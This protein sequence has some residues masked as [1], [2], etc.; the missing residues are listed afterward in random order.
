MI[1]SIQGKVIQKGNDFLIIS[2]AG[3]G[4]QVFATHEVVDQAQVGD[5]ISLFSQLIVREDSLSLYGFADYQEKVYFNLL[6]GVSGVGPRLAISIL[7]TL[8]IDTIN[9]SVISEQAEIFNRVVGVGRKTAQKIIIQ[10]QGKIQVTEDEKAP[11]GGL[12][13]TDI[14]VLDALTALGYSIVEAQAAIQTIP[15]DTAESVEDRLLAA[16]RYFS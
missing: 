15:R 10:L 5:N 11:V 9:R 3:I 4:F 7:S 16:L 6:L 8:S 13:E 2:V 12:K 14:E 1:A